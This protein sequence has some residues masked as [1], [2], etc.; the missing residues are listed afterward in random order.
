[1]S[2]AAEFRQRRRAPKP[3]LVKDP[4]SDL[5]IECRRPDL[6]EMAFSGLMA[7]PALDRVRTLIAERTAADTASSVLDNRPLPTIVDRARA[8]GT[9]I[10]EWVCLAAVSP[11]VVMAEHEA[12]ADPGVLWIEE[13]P[14]DFRQAIYQQ[15]FRAPTTAGADF[16]R[17]EPGSAPPGQGGEAVRDEALVAV[18]DAES[19]GGARP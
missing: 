6:I 9:F 4:G 7:W 12:L 11:R 18:G 1:M 3:I 8:A 14:F 15:T 13:L 16:R 10:D 5:T 19:D 2:T 17:D